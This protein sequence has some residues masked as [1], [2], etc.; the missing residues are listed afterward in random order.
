M[1]HIRLELH[2]TAYRHKV[3]SAVE[4]MIL[5]AFY[6]ANKVFKFEE[7][8]KDIEEYCQLNDS[9]RE[10]IINF[11]FKNS[12]YMNAINNFDEISEEFR[13]TFERIQNNIESDLKEA[14]YILNRIETRKLYKFI[15]QTILKEPQEID[16]NKI[17]NEVNK[18]IFL[19][20]KLFLILL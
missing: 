20:F 13:K 18:L 7:K 14:Q 19:Y 3:C 4:L 10:D 5:D 17:K 9:I 16:E 11:K 15:S 8:I 2:K 12:I 6:K 1:Y